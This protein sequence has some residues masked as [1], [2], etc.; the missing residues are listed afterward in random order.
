M[1]PSMSDILHH[2]SLFRVV[3]ISG[4]Y[5]GG[6]TSLSV[7]LAMQLVKSGHA[8]T[9]VSNVPLSF[10]ADA[11]IQRS[12]VSDIHD[13]AIILDEAWLELGQGVDNRKIRDWLAYLRKN[14]QYILLPSVLPLARIVSTFTVEREYSLTPLGLPLWIYQWRLN[15][16]SSSN[17]N[18][19]VG[20]FYWWRPSSIF[21]FYDHTYKPSED[22]Y[23]YR[24]DKA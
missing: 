14:N 17:R 12:D 18:R 3:Q 19:N 5:G 10:E 4:R 16:G 23:V 8:H 2:T 13:A 7:A 9:I 1:L 22:Y 6:K 11:T 24:F 15:I 21:P 20:R